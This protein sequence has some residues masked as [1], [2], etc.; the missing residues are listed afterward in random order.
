MTD[1]EI[2][3][4]IVRAGIANGDI[5]EQ[6]YKEAIEG[7]QALLLAIRTAGLVI[8]EDWKPIL[9]AETLT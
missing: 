7:G 2:I 4:R 3:D 9:E 1:E 8:E 6:D 5:S